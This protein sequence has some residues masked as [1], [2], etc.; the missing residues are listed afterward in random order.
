MKSQLD[1][2][3]KVVFI[4]TGVDLKKAEDRAVQDSQRAL[5]LAKVF[6]RLAYN[7]VMYQGAFIPTKNYTKGVC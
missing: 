4:T 7:V 5:M 6:E 2:I 3:D 1:E